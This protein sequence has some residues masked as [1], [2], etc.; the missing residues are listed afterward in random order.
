MGK[1]R[2]V[3]QVVSAI[4][5]LLTLVYFAIQA[6]QTNNALLAA[7]RQGTMAAD[8][9]VLSASFSGLNVPSLLVK[10]PAEL[11]SGEDFA[12]G[13]WCAAF[14]RVREFAWFQYKAGILNETAWRSYLGP[15]KRLL[16]L[17]S[18]LKWWARFAEEVDPEFR[19]YID[20][21]IRR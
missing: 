19:A 4:A 14:V 13:A 5:I 10:D 17:P 8:V 15:T 3:A 1:R 16:G 11:T 18:L 9:E 2:G 7:S 6:R 20:S 21:E 12:V